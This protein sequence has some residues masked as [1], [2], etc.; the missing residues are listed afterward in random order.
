MTIRDAQQLG[1]EIQRTRNLRG[2]S[3]S[4]LAARSGVSRNYLHRIEKGK[5]N[6]TVE[7]L[8]AIAQALE[9][10]VGA[11]LGETNSTPSEV[12]VF[13]VRLQT[14]AIDIDN[15]IKALNWKGIGVEE[16]ESIAA[17]I[18]RLYDKLTEEMSNVR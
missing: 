17:G 15:A 14:L 6:L 16:G 18:E 12:E 4:D 7:K 5:N 3:L 10:T 9:V 11:L 2:M 8:V 13:K 1:C